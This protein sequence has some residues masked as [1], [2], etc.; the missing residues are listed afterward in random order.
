MADE[1]RITQDLFVSITE[2]DNALG[3][4]TQDVFISISENENAFARITGDWLLSITNV[5]VTATPRSQ[6]IIIG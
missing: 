5:P 1:G 3:R 2:N 4:V 6:V